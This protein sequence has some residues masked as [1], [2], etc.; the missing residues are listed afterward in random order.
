M[1]DTDG[2]VREMKNLQVFFHGRDPTKVCPH[3]Q[4]SG[5]GFN[6][7]KVLELHMNSLQ[8]F[9]SHGHCMDLFEN[10]GNVTNM[11]LSINFLRCLPLGV[12]AYL[13]SV[14]E[15]DLSSNYLSYVR[16]DCLPKSLKILYLF[17]DFIDNP[18]PTVFSSLAPLDLKAYCS[19]CDQNLNDFLSWVNQTND[20]FLSPI[21]QLWCEFP[22][23]SKRVGSLN[24]LLRLQSSCTIYRG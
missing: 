15:M 13:T 17:N 11:N 3:Q 20:T 10:L 2:F 8:S 4:G 16:P 1:K 19:L 6:N 21:E 7:L 14:K 22:S 9:W 12:F 5:I 18:D 24:S 23:T